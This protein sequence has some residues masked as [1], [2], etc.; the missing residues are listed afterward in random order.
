[1]MNKLVLLS[2]VR[3][4]PITFILIVLLSV[5]GC[6]SL[7]MAP[8]KSF[9][10]KVAYSYGIHTAVLQSAANAVNN[11]DI[12]LEEGKQVLNLADESR[13][14]LDA[15]RQAFHIGDIDTANGKLM[16]ATSILSQ[17]QTYLRSKQ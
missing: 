17:L 2:D 16:L 11:Q 15:S 6:A 14:L 9:E 13:A 12:S 5:A 1:M 10:Q 3:N 7:G 4:K 8:A